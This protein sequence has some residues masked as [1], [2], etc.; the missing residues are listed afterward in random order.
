M[1]PKPGRRSILL[2]I[3]FLAAV[4]TGVLLLV[5]SRPADDPGAVRFDSRL[6]GAARAG[7]AH[8]DRQALGQLADRSRSLLQQEAGWIRSLR[9]EGR[10]SGQESEPSRMIDARDQIAAARI[11]LESGDKAGLQDALARIRG[12]F[13]NGQGLLA[14]TATLEAN[15]QPVRA[16]GFSTAAT[17]G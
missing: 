6:P 17:H 14:A 3:L 8:E 16:D 5:L 11:A 1:A 9:L 12:V 10:L 15:G 13:R 2:S 4:A 7:Y